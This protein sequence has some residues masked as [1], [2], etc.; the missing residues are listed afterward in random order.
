VNENSIEGSAEPGSK[1]RVNNNVVTIVWVCQVFP[2]RHAGAFHE[3]QNRR[4]WFPITC[5]AFTVGVFGI[6]QAGNFEVSLR[7]ASGLFHASK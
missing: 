2:F 7:I 1:K 4:R 5:F 6:G 3:L